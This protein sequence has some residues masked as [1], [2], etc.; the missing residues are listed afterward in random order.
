MSLYIRV[1][2]RKNVLTDT[3]DTL[4]LFAVHR[5]L[6]LTAKAGLLSIPQA[7]TEESKP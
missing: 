1:P 3:A 6:A 7:P 4:L 2:S 5:N